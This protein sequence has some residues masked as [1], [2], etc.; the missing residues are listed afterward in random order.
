MA[1]LREEVRSTLG[2]GRQ[3]VVRSATVRDARRVCDLLDAVA[4]EPGPYVLLVPGQFDHHDWKSRIG[5]CRR[6]DVSLLVVAEV[7]GRPAGVAGLHPDPHP[8]AAHVR[9]L[10]MSV[11]R[12]FRQ[13]G[14][15]TAVVTALIGWARDRGVVKVE[16]GVFPHNEPAI[17]FYRRHGFV[18]EGRRRAHYVRGAAL[19]DEVL[20]GR[21]VGEATPNGV[22]AGG[23]P[24]D[25]AGD[26][27]T[28]PAGDGRV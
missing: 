20:M 26:G 3:V 23:P 27:A 15:G 11:A 9:Q 16:L 4:A 13:L 24:A 25:A 28:G 8:G 19:L 18:D 7:D 5:E 12:E 21:I 6:D 22:A 17:A 10:G 1:L 14:V 2:D